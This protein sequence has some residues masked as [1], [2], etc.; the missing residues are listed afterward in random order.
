M[1]RSKDTKEPFLR[2][3]KN[4]VIG[5]IDTE[6]DTKNAVEQLL[7]DGHAP[8]DILVFSG[9]DDARRIDFTGKENGVFAQLYR[10]FYKVLSD[11][12]K[13]FDQYG[14]HVLANRFVISAPADNEESSKQ[15]RDILKAN[16]GHFIHYF[17]QWT[18]LQLN[19]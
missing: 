3:P 11:D 14:E 16:N 7:T 12:Q 9:E 1:S 13:I 6:S 18:Y 19:K 10:T 15:V 8:K 2:H 17:G 5:V 4:I